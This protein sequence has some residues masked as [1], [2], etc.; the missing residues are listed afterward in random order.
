MKWCKKI[1]WDFHDNSMNINENAWHFS[2]TRWNKTNIH[3]FSW[4]SM[5]MF[6][7]LMKSNEH[8]GMSMKTPCKSMKHPWKLMKFYE[9]QWDSDEHP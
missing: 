2:D 7:I 6:E 1:D 5:N 4:N 8:N 3:I 9:Q